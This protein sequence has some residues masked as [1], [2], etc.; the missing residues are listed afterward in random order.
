MVEFRTVG[1]DTQSVGTVMQK[2][3]EVPEWQMWVLHSQTGSQKSRICGQ[4]HQRGHV[5]RK[6]YN[7]TCCVLEFILLTCDTQTDQV[8]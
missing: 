8:I 3:L 1:R 2:S 5:C 4:Y 7:P 6:H